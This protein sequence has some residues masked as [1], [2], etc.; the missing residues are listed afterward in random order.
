MKIALSKRTPRLTKEVALVFT[1]T[2]IYVLSS[3]SNVCSLESSFT[4]SSEELPKPSLIFYFHQLQDSSR[5]EGIIFY[6][7]LPLLPPHK[8]S[9]I[10]LQ[11]CIW[12]D[13]H[14]FLITTFLTTRLLLNAIYHLIDWW[15]NVN[16]CLFTWWSDS[17]F[18]S[19]HCDTG[20]HWIWTRID[21]HPCIT[22]EPTS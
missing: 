6:F 19:Q 15:Y 14:I 4:E 3:S 18:L 9:D 2:S 13:C 22:M 5:S 17:E 8:H 10:H 11:I 16:F 20:N 12:D 1:L 21:H 7:F